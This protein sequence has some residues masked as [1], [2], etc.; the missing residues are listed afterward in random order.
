[1]CWILFF[2]TC[3]TSIFLLHKK[4]TEVNYSFVDDVSNDYEK[5]QNEYIANGSAEVAK[6]EVKN[7]TWRDDYKF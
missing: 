7:L 4:K 5:S 1:M 2:V 6:S 3:L